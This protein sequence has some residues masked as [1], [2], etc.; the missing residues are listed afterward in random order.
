MNINYELLGSIPAMDAFRNSLPSLI[1]EFR[2]FEPQRTAART[3]IQAAYD[4]GGPAAVAEVLKRL[5]LD[6]DAQNK[7]A[8]GVTI[9]LCAQH[10]YGID[11]NE[12]GTITAVIDAIESAEQEL[13]FGK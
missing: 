8:V 6:I 11:T 5:P 4:A 2:S 9:E 13:Q 3:E 1:A 7:I 10:F 12:C